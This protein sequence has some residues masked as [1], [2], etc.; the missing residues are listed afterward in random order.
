MNLPRVYVDFNEMPTEDEVLLSK[1]DSKAD[2]SGTVIEFAEGMVVAVYSEDFDEDGN[3]DNLIAEGTAQRNHHGG[4]TSAAK[5]LLKIN[6]RG[7]RH[8][9][10]ESP[11]T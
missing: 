5:W 8:E 11:E 7:I 10:D 4:W 3:Q 2:S 1:E 9:S 6:D